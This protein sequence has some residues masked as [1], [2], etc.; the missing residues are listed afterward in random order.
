MATVNNKLDVTDLD[1]DQIKANLKSFLSNQTTFSGYDFTGSGLNQILNLLAYNTHYN[2]YY[3]NMLANEMFMDSASITNSIVSK[4]RMLNYTP[5]SM[6]GATATVQ[7]T[8][9]GVTSGS[10]VT[11]DK[12]SKFEIIISHYLHSYYD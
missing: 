10:T 5:R 6:V 7:T 8:I 9:A 3:M 4:A 2:A 1:F 11:I 12:F